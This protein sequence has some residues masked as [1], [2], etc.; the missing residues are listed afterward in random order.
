MPMYIDADDYIKYCE[1][2]W[3]PLNIDAVL[4]Q[5]KITNVRENIHGRWIVD[6]DGNIE[7]SVCGH[8]GVGDLYCE[9][10]GAEMGANNGEIH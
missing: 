3:I 4:A 10:C 6:E 5:K 2:N 7:C 1:D 8:H 9:R